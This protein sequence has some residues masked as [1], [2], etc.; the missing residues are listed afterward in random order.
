MAADTAER[1]GGEVIDESVTVPGRRRAAVPEPPLEQLP[2]TEPEPKSQ[3]PEPHQP[4]AQQPARPHHAAAIAETEMY[5]VIDDLQPVEHIHSADNVHPAEWAAHR[6]VLAPEPDP[7]EEARAVVRRRRAARA[8][9]EQ[10][11]RASRPIKL[12]VGVL[13]VAGVVGVVL[14]AG[15]IA[16][17][18]GW[19]STSD[20]TS[21]I[22]AAVA[23]W[24]AILLLVR[25]CG[26]RVV[27]VGAFTGVLIGLAVGFPE[28][29]SLSAAAVLA[30]ATFGGLGMLLTRPARVLASLGELLL[31]AFI[32][33]I[34]AVVVTGYAADLRPLRFRMVLLG[35]VFVGALAI[36]WQLGR[37]WHS[38]GRRGAALVVVGIVVLVGSVVYIQ[39]IKSY[40][41]R[42]VVQ[43]LTDAKDWVSRMLGATP[44][45]V[46]AVVG[47][48]AI[49]WGVTTRRRRRQGWWMCAF[50]AL[51]AAGVATSLIQPDTSLEEAMQA[52]GYDVLIGGAIGLILVGLD[53]LLTGGG[54]RAQTPDQVDVVRPEPPRFA[55]LI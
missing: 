15:Q 23:T 41:S 43:G 31:S 32:G 34:G 55:P 16:D 10:A 36:A 13:A 24:V 17:Q 39:A 22:G 45:P 29:W 21:R 6:P 47:F 51:G 18:Q 46:E 50:G 19:W 38:L 14:S 42:D 9:A 1:A 48:P 52:T 35:I 53:A 3:Q 26:G 4:Q 44:R 40:G 11:A 5:P 37:G 27:V 12:A 33:L 20:T 49:V 25:R 30:G 7:V 8:E 28:P 54:R 2:P